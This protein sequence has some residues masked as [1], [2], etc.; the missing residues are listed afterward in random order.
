[1]LTTSVREVTRDPKELNGT[2]SW[3][4]GRILLTG[5]MERTSQGTQPP[6]WA[7]MARRV[8]TDG[9]QSA[10]HG[11]QSCGEAQEPR[12]ISGSQ[13]CDRVRAKGEGG[14]AL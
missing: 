12:L 14:T 4:Q 7:P 6:G 13:D 3:G 11:P 5:G 9:R 2:Q 1:M 8:L 10:M